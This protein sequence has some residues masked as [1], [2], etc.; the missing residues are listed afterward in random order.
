[1]RIESLKTEP[2]RAGRY[3]ITLD[4]GKKMALY[5]Q[6]V[7][8]FGLYSGKEL[9]DEEFGQL[10]AASGAMSAKMR[11]VRIVAAS[12]VSKKD[13]Q[14]RLVQKGEDP[15]QA[16]EAV[17]WMEEMHL[18]DDE[19]TARQIVSRCAAKGYGLSRAKQALYEKKI[20]K[21]YWD[22]A[23]AVY[24]DQTEHMLRFL[25]SRLEDTSDQKEVKKAIEALL[26]RGHSYA[27][28]RSA[29]QQMVLD[30]DEFPEE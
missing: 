9:S 23:L 4:G 29:L 17:A 1:M 27:E 20:P 10:E 8:D 19:E 5:R 14:Q 12:A 25:R 30:P 15:A 2:D 11:A 6:T 7:E 3:W 28:I 24:P 16:A 21:C 26:R 13:L 22:A 18:V